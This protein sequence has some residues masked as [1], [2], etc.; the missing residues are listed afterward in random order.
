VAPG[1]RESE[2]VVANSGPRLSGEQAS[3][4]FEP[5]RRLDPSRS[6]ATGGFGLGLAVV[7]AVAEA[8]GGSV[9]AE[10]LPDGGLAVAV[11]LPHAAERQ[12]DMNANGTPSPAPERTVAMRRP[13]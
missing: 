1:G 4:I 2:L 9:R 6:R 3:T 7:R 12:P 5:F 13:G 8:H 10:P 11:A